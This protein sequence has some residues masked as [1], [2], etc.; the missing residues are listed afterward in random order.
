MKRSQLALILL[1]AAVGSSVFAASTP[2]SRVAVVD[3]RPVTLTC[4]IY[5]GQTLIWIRDCETLG[6]GKVESRSDG[7]VALLGSGITVTFKAGSPNVMVNQLAVMAPI[8]AKVV[9]GKLMAPFDFVC[10]TFGCSYGTAVEPVT[11]ISTGLAATATRQPASRGA[12]QANSRPSSRSVPPPTYRPIQTFDSETPLPRSGNRIVGRVTFAG[13]P[14]PD[15]DLKLGKPNGSSIELLTPAKRA[16]TDE[17]GQFAFDDLPEGKYIVLAWVGDNPEYSNQ[18]SPPVS[19]YKGVE[20]TVSDINM[21]KM[22]HPVSP[23][24]GDTVTPAGGRV[25]FKCTA[26]PPAKDYNFSVTDSSSSTSLVSGS[27][28]KPAIIL[29]VSL[30]DPGHKYVWRVT[31]VDENGDSLGMSPGAGS[32]PWGFFLAQPGASAAA[33]D[34][35]PVEKAQAIYD[36]GAACKREGRI[37][38]AV[39]EWRKVLSSEFASPDPGLQTV[40]A[41]SLV[42]LGYAQRKSGDLDGALALFNKVLSDYPENKGLCAESLL[43]DGYILEEKNDLPN[44]F[45]HLRDVLKLYPDQVARGTMAIGHIN[46]IKAKGLSLTAA[47]QAELDSLTE[48]HDMVPRHRARIEVDRNEAVANGSRDGLV[49][50]CNDP[51]VLASVDQLDKLARAQLQIGDRDNARKTFGKCLAL[52]ARENMPEECS[53]LKTWSSFLL[54][55]HDVAIA[56]SSRVLRVYP[57]CRYMVEMKYLLAQAYHYG[58][59]LDKAVKAYDELADRYAGSVDPQERIYD[60]SALLWCGVI[61]QDAG[62]NDEAI[63]RFERCTKEFPGTYWTNSASERLKALQK[64]KDEVK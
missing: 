45:A 1:L 41:E 39:A 5:N 58:G 14:L 19:L 53:R 23:G 3:G 56:E 15:I 6:W 8:A 51:M 31:A 34:P 55:D 25:E 20:A 22:L 13:K 7:S 17:N 36:R 49:A 54:W 12:Q 50:L 30:L 40:R 9:G 48:A 32:T 29:D 28:D 35:T 4:A 10:K 42:E 64:G 43:Y 16:G 27:S 38:Q 47:E 44:A 37:P 62:R 63:A 21:R 61:L 18:A 60:N 24:V 26:C 33:F 46:D 59:K 11:R 52:A 2:R 57:D